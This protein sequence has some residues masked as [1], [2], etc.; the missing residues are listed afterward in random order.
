M[1]QSEA[2]PHFRL[3]RNTF[4]IKMVIWKQYNLNT[5][6]GICLNYPDLSALYIYIILVLLLTNL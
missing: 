2:R 6:T 3:G 5:Q 1:V 4:L